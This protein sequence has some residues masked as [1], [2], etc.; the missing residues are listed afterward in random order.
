M[1]GWAISK[2]KYIWLQCPLIEMLSS[3]TQRHFS[4]LLQNSS[5]GF[6]FPSSHS[7]PFI[8]QFS[9]K[10]SPNYISQNTAYANSLAE[11]VWY[12]LKYICL[13]ILWTPSLPL[14]PFFPSI[15]SHL[16]TCWSV[17]HL[18]LF[19]NEWGHCAAGTLKI[20]PCYFHCKLPSWSP[21]ACSHFVYF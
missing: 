5:L 18:W 17:I 14:T 7:Q 13:H 15:H 10:C 21:P 19:G 9:N 6:L 16:S 20:S 4:S 3:H 11:C 1:V 8:K 2:T 12:T